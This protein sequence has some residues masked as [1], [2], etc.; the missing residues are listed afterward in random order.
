MSGQFDNLLKELD[1]LTAGSEA[2]AKALPTDSE[3]DKKIQAAAEDGDGKGDGDADD[4][5]GAADG[6]ADDKPM[7]KSFKVK[8]EDGT[9][10]EAE[11]GTV[12]VKALGERLDATE[13]M[14]A[15]ALGGAVAL[16]KSQSA[17][18]EK[19]G[20]LLKSLTEKVNKLSSEGRGRKTTVVL[21]EK[22]TDTSLAK[23]HQDGIT[24]QEFLL[25]ANS[26]F[27]AKKLTGLELTTIDV[28]LRSGQPLDPTL[29]SKVMG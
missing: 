21:T 22:Q 28:S 11:D 2:L 3:D 5:G 6:D 16:I 18:I 13:G 7:A 12:L 26:A 10:V 8:L 15:K 29:I 25:K 24:P 20:D 9:E 4:K 19:Q 23:S 17:V 27:D 14:L 1:V